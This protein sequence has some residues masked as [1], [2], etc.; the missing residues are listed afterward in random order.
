MQESDVTNSGFQLP[1]PSTK[2]WYMDLLNFLSQKIINI[3][4]KIFPH[5]LFSVMFSIIGIYNSFLM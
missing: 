5:L 4:V 2:L 1:Y 3:D